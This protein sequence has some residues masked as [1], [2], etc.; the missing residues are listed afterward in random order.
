MKI[1]AKVDIF[2]NNRY[3]FR[4]ENELPCKE[5]LIFCATA[6]KLSGGIRKERFCY[7]MISTLPE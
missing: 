2:S 3:S 5:L 1:F 7:L 4:S 6:L